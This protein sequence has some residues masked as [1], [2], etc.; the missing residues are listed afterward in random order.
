MTAG[1]VRQRLRATTAAAARSASAAASASVDSIHATWLPYCSGPRFAG[2][3]KGDGPTRSP[4][5]HRGQNFADGSTPL[6]HCG[7]FSPSGD[8]AAGSDMLWPA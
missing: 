1:P 8:V 5:P 6:P 3:S 2:C 7:H 4:L